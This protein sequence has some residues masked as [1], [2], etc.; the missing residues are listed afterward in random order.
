MA[1]LEALACRIPSLV[2]TTCHFPEL[3]AAEGA[4]VVPPDAA[5]I[6]Q[7]LRDLLERTP[8]E[9]AELGLRGRRLIERDYTWDR[10]A[11]H[12]AA[13]YRWLSGGGP[14]PDVVAL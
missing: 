9:R 8:H 1:V 11:Q 10:Q 14:P 12:L 13:V 5:A 4:V 7:G 2:T 6:T 3:A